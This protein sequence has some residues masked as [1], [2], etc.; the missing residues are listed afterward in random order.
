MQFQVVSD[1]HLESKEDFEITPLAPYLILAGDIGHPRHDNYKRFIQRCSDNWEHVF[2]ITG[3]HEYYGSVMSEVDDYIKETY[4]NG[5]VHF[6]NKETYLLNDLLI[7]GCTL[8]TD[9]P[10]RNHR[11][12]KSNINDYAYIRSAKGKKLTPQ[13]SV[14]IHK[15][16][17]QFILD[18]ATRK[19]LII[20]HH[21]A[22]DK[23]LDPKYKD[24]TVLNMAYGTDLTTYVN[25]HIKAWITGHTHYSSEEKIGETIMFSNCVGH[26]G[27][28]TGYDESRILTIF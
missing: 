17:L 24:T 27:Q 25:E 28:V 7:I 20:T 9:I 14:E 3:N 22:Y 12:I 16:H 18:N 13:K 11:Y 21:V 15:E 1:V 2:L 6:L 4:D 23:M 8:W 5:N 19:C 26:E 10:E